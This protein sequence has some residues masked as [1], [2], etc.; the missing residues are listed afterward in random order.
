MIQ[1][2][3]GAQVCPLTCEARRADAAVATNK[4]DACGIVQAGGRYALIYV[5]FTA[6]PCNG[7]TFRNKERKQE[8]PRSG[9][10]AVSISVTHAQFIPK[11]YCHVTLGRDEC[12]WTVATQ[13]HFAKDF[14]SYANNNNNKKKIRVVSIKHKYIFLT[15][16]AA[17]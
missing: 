17:R 16:S 8:H 1:G 14:K 6:G 11:V 4:V 13:N 5:D 7:V 10:A 9:R 15:H 3:L 12:S 2:N